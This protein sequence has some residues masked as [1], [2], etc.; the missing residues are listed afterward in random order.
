MPLLEWFQ[1]GLTTQEVGALLKIGNEPI[2]CL[3]ARRELLEL[4]ARGT[5]MRE[6]IGDDAVWRAVR[7]AYA[8]EPVA[9]SRRATLSATVAPSTCP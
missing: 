9:E 5:V 3:A 6:P 7:Y 2:D 8:R 1:S 4:V